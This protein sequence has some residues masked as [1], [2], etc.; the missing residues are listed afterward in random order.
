MNILVTGE[1]GYVSSSLAVSMR[2]KGH[3]VKQTS[4][5]SK[6]NEDELNNVDVIVHC[7]AMV[8]KKEKK[9]TIEE[10]ER[11][12]HKKT[13]ELASLAKEQGVKLFI[14]M[15]TMSVYGTAQGIINETTPLKPNTFYG[16][17]KLH[18]E[19]SLLNMED[20]NFGIAIIRPPM[21]YG[22][23]AP[24][25]Y[26]LLSKLA[27]QTPIFPLIKNQRS[28]I[29]IDNL[30][31]FINLVA[32]SK[33]RGVFHPQNQEYVQTSEL[34]KQIA[35]NH[36]KKIILSPFSGKALMSLFGSQRLVNKVF[37]DLVY[38]KELSH[39]RGN[40][41]QKVGFK[42]SVSLSEI[43]IIDKGV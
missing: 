9:F 33:D 20:K 5:R 3:K 35:E 2:A 28:M 19:E 15:S 39:F 27:K 32:N 1:K 22:Y 21:V 14:F 40:V 23:Q 16:I 11:V 26:Q 17:S 38:S 25:N 34:V 12:N 4:I 6:I 13:V 24:G 37:G 7:A 8:H 10:Y 29:F 18:A 36:G 31:E 43:P 30:I 42:E 41:Y